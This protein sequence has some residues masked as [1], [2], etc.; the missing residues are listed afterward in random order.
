MERTA[1]N[2]AQ[3]FTVLSAYQS[4]FKPAGKL[5]AII[6]SV[7]VLRSNSPISRPLLDA[8]QAVVQFANKQNSAA[9]ASAKAALAGKPDAV[10]RHAALEIAAF[11]CYQLKDYAAC[12]DYYL[13]ILKANANNPAILN[14]LAYLLAVKLH[15]PAK[16]LAYAERCNALLIQQAGS[17]HYAPNGDVLDTLGW[18]R[19]LNGDL[20][21]AVDAL[22]H[23]L[24]YNPPATAYYH[25]ARVLVAQKN[26]ARAVEILKTG[27]K[28][29]ESTHD[30][31]LPRAQE[32]L[33]KIQG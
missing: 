32:L 1:G 25:L 33:K 5:D 20:S 21:G 30:P 2:P 17:G 26:M 12:R 8:A 18:I 27:I 29:A 31:I 19:F 28:L 22:D 24:R 13:D 9:L 15:E 10:T 3:F 14:N 11:S 23:S 6:K 7:D 4:A 16:A